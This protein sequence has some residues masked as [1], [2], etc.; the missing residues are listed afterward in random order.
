MRNDPVANNTNSF[1]SPAIED[2]DAKLVVVLD[3]V[4]ALA[5]SFVIDDP[6]ARA[7]LHIQGHSKSIV[8]MGLSN[9]AS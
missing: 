2:R 3:T 6:E 4:A 7:V 5:I 1:G 9:L 8:P